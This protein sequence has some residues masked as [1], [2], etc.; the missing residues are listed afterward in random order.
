MLCKYVSADRTDILSDKLIRFT[1][2]KS[3]NDPFECRFTVNPLQEEERVAEADDYLAEWAQTEDWLRERMGQLGILSL[4]RTWNNILMW[5]H[6]ADGH[7]GFVI[8]FDEN[9]AWFNEGKA[10]FVETPPIPEKIDLGLDGLQDVLYRTDV[11]NIDMFADVP[12]EAFITKS[13][14]WAYEEEVRKFRHLGEASKCNDDVHLFAFS[15]EVISE[16]ILGCNASNGLK[17]T[18]RELQESSYPHMIVKQ[19]SVHRRAFA[20]QADIVHQET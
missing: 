1:S 18:I 17:E 7:E 16:V 4:T 3:L 13:K 11:P 5:S 8:C 2:Y 6:Y 14:D 19:A 12:I 10:F 20:I 15:P 9:H